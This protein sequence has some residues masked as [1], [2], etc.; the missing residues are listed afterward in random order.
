MNIKAG[1]EDAVVE[2]LSRNPQDC[3]T[4]DGEGESLNI[5]FIDAEIELL[6][7][8]QKEGVELRNVHRYLEKPEKGQSAN[9]HAFQNKFQSILLINRVL[10]IQKLLTREKN[11][12]FLSPIRKV[13]LKEFY[14]NPLAGH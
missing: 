8:D 1:E 2:P 10:F 3:C 13:I 7:K 14:D 4:D 11:N 9:V 12:E 6:I 5:I